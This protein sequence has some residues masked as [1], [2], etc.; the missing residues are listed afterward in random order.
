MF[1]TVEPAQTVNVL[2]DRTAMPEPHPTTPGKAMNMPEPSF[3]LWQPEMP[4]YFVKAVP[5]TSIQ[6]TAAG[7]TAIVN[8]ITGAKLVAMCPAG[9][10]VICPDPS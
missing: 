9:A 1:V 2:Q 3:L 6:V 7:L 8:K 10:M 4:S 5:G